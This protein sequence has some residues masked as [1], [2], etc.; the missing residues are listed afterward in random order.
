[1]GHDRGLAVDPTD[2]AV[3]GE[4]VG[5][6]VLLVGRVRSGLGAWGRGWASGPSRRAER[7][8]ELVD[9]QREGA[10]QERS[11][12]VSGE[13]PADEPLLGDLL[14]HAAV[15]PHEGAALVVGGGRVDAERLEAA[16]GGEL[17]GLVED[18]LELGVAADPAG[19]DGH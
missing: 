9:E 15:G 14:G 12:L 16:G 8:E 1:G 3:P 11:G 17:A 6:V 5:H 4:V 18:L 2:G 13:A 19:A 10:A 7:G